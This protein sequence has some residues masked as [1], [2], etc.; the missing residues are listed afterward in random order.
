MTV[1]DSGGYDPHG[2]CDECGGPSPRVRV[3]GQCELAERIHK[4][5]DEREA[6]LKAELEAHRVTAGILGEVFGPWEPLTDEGRWAKEK[7]D[8]ITGEFEPKLVSARI[9]ELKAENARLV[10]RVKRLE[11]RQERAID[12]L[13]GRGV[14]GGS[15]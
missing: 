9:D 1:R 8:R 15:V 10:A 4:E 13:S 5:R 14:D 12:L 11:A 7:F 6:E 2:V 3:C